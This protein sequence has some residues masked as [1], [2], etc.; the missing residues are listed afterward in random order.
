MDDR[1]KETRKKLMAFTLVHD[2]HGRILGYLGNITRQ[3][4]MLIGEKALEINQHIT[5]VLEFPDE[6]PGSAA[7]KLTIAARVARCVPDEESAREFDIGFE[8]DEVSPEQA[9]IIDSL[10]ERYHFRHREWA[11]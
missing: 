10:L 5:L 11:R 4:A 8:F 9:K 3:G 2:Q 1:R 6:L 7:R